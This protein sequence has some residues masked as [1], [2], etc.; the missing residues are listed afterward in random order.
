MFCRFMYLLLFVGCEA[1]EAPPEGAAGA[2]GEQ[3]N[4][5]AGQGGSGSVSCS[6]ESNGSCAPGCCA[7]V[8]DRYEI[9]TDLSC[10]R[11][12]VEQGTVEC[13]DAT[14]GCGGT[15]TIPC[16]ITRSTDEGW[17]VSVIGSTPADRS[18]CTR[19]GDPDVMDVLSDGP[20][21]P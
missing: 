7:L 14:A 19:T 4:P 2:G 9:P 6:I 13:Y 17:E 20:D 16:V 8:G 11:K 15:T 18:D 10:R 3:G 1:A 21:C 5:N 12:V